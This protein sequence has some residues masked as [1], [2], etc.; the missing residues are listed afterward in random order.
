MGSI[1]KNTLYPIRL[2][3]STRPLNKKYSWVG[4]KEII[5]L[6]RKDREVMPLGKVDGNVRKKKPMKMSQ[7]MEFVKQKWR[8]WFTK[9]T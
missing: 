8:W 7:L 5:I 1:P 9:A 2:V 6:M 4:Y 3:L